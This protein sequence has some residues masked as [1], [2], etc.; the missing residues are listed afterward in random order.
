[1]SGFVRAVDGWCV[2]SVSASVIVEDGIAS[3]L[4]LL[5]TIDETWISEKR[6]F[7]LSVTMDLISGRLVLSDLIVLLAS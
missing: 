6:C 7:A 3:L 1:M 5:S 2:G 4:G